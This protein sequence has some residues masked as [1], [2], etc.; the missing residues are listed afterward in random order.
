MSRLVGVADRAQQLKVDRVVYRRGRRADCCEQRSAPYA[1]QLKPITSVTA[2]YG[3]YEG[4][5]ELWVG[6]TKRFDV[7]AR[8]TGYVK[9]T[10]MTT[11]GGT[12]ATGRAHLL[13]WV[14][15]RTQ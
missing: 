6:S 3:H 14:Y 1:I 8:L 7:A 13:G 4:P 9:V 10:V 12:R 11:T 2:R 15:R 5:T